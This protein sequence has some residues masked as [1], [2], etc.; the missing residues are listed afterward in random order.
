MDSVFLARHGETEWNVL[1]RRQ[2]QLDSSLTPRGQAQARALA[3]LLRAQEIDTVFTSPLGRAQSTA[4]VIAAASDVPAVVLDDLAEVHH[5]QFA[6]LSD[7]DI[8]ARYPGELERRTRDKYRWTFPGGESYADADVRAHRVLDLIAGHG[9]RRPAIVAHEMIGK[10]L[11][12]RLLGLGPDEAL[13]LKHPND[14][15][16]VIGFASATIRCLRVS[17]ST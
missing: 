10:L 1:R 9:A 12:R 8:E 4:K 11:R 5:G 7:E 17:P 3:A 13:A 16:Y 14:T 15:V 2:G 6:G